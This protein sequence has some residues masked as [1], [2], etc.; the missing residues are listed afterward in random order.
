MNYTGLKLTPAIFADIMVELLDGKQFERQDAIKL[1]QAHFV[2]NGGV[3]ENKDYV[4]V[5]KKAAQNLKTKGMV[6][7]GYGVWL[8]N[9]AQ[10]EVETFSAAENTAIPIVADKEMGSGKQAIYV[11]F[12]DIYK[13]WALSNNSTIWECKIGR[14]DRDPIQRIINQAGTSYPELPHIALIIHCD[15][16]NKLESA[17]H[18]ILKYKKRWIENAPGKEWFYTSP[19]EIEEIFS[20][21]LS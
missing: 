17:L 6:N 11:Y 2:K 4:A 18:G 19:E 14:T 12:Y 1:V 7:R 20:T 8:L 9:I 10:E 15:D 16:S 3:L 13:K 5:F 21:L